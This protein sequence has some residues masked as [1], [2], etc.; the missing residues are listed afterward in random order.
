MSTSV[1]QVSITESNNIVSITEAPYKISVTQNNPSVVISTPFI[2]EVSVTPV[3]SDWSESDNSET[4]FIK[5]K[6]TIPSGNQVIDWT[7][8]QGS[9]NIHAGN[10]TN[11]TYSVQDGE[12]SQNN[13]TDADHTKLNGIADNANNYTLPDATASVK[14]GVIV[15]TSS[16]LNISNGTISLGGHMHSNANFANS[17]FMSSSHYNKLEAIASGAE[18]NVQA[19]WNQSTSS[20]DAFIQNKPTIPSGNQILDWTTD[21]GSSNIHVN[22]LPAI[23]LS[24]VQEASSESAQLALTTQEGDVVVRTDENKSYVRN[25]GT[26]GNMNDFTLLRTPTDAVLSVNGSTGAV[27]LNHDTLPGFVAN[28]HIDWTTDQGSTNIH[29]GNIPT[30]G[31]TEDDIIAL[32]LALG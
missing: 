23:A 14:G 12:L 9:T 22:N 30:T 6:P 32:S 18:V 20:H 27:T 13:F 16:G 15:N 3:Q 21:Q 17:G 29:A 19:D 7:S 25:S 26:A 10:Y 28:E 11:T 8:D 24:N 1:N 4:S 5:N 31:V 2:R